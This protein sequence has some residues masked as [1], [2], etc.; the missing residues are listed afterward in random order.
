[1]LCPGMA[2]GYARAR[3]QAMVLHERHPDWLSSSR[4]LQEEICIS[5]RNSSSTTGTSAGEDAVDPTSDCADLCGT[6]D[7]LQTSYRRLDTEA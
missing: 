1:M 6:L 4:F 3:R 7:D 2:W 5:I